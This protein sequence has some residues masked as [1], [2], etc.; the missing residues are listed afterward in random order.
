MD[1]ILII[2]FGKVGS[3]IGNALHNNPAFQ[4]TVYDAYLQTAQVESRLSEQLVSEATVLIISVPDD[5][6][7]HIVKEL[8]HYQLGNKTV[9]HTS[10]MVKLDVLKPLQKAGAETAVLH[11]LQSFSSRNADPVIW[12]DIW[13]SFEGTDSAKKIAIRITDS[14]GAKL[15]SVTARQKEALHVAA[16]FSAN[17]PVALFAAAEKILAD[18]DLDKAFIQP[19]IQNVLKNFKAQ[20]AD[21]ILSGPLQRGDIETVQAHLDFLNKPSYE[22]LKKLYQNL[23]STL[24]NN[25]QIAIHNRDKLVRIIKEL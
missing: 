15:I 12:Q 13:C 3:A 14:L 20:N 16:V 2:G 5:S 21:Q 8:E 25:P 6:I 23:C 19:L 18:A 10:G 11:P 22:E 4:I 17:L 1:N 24:L 9:L 7:A